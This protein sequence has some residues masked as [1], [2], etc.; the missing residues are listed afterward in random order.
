MKPY[1]AGAG[2]GPG[3]FATARRGISATASGIKTT[4]STTKKTILKTTRL[5]LRPLKLGDAPTVRKWG[6]FEEVLLL[7]NPPERLAVYEP[8]LN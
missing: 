8:G 4:L 5:Q 6:V 3:S 2:I 1:E 7:V